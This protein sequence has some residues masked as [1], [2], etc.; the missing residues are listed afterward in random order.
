MCRLPGIVQHLTQLHEWGVLDSLW[1]HLISQ[2]VPAAIKDCRM[3]VT[4]SSDGGVGEGSELTPG[5][6]EYWSL[7]ESLLSDCHLSDENARL[8]IKLMC[9]G[10]ADNKAECHTEESIKLL[11]DTIQ[12]MLRLVEN[13]YAFL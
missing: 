10:Y 11:A 5:K 9:E 3:A 2:L 8:V 1:P 4:S 12:A 6:P 7:L 13:K